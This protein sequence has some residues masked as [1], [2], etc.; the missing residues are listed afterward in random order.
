MIP[1]KLRKQRIVTPNTPD[2]H[3]EL[4]RECQGLIY[5]GFGLAFTANTGSGNDLARPESAA[6]MLS[7]RPEMGGFQLVLIRTTLLSG[8]KIFL[9]NRENSH[10]VD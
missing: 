8:V 6:A 10:Y 3:L 2:M 9:S 1:D 7:D 4:S 5:E